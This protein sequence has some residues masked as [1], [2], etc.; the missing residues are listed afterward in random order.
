MPT[1]G[2]D[3]TFQLYFSMGLFAAPTLAKYMFIIVIGDYGSIW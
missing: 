2:R 3:E 1:Q